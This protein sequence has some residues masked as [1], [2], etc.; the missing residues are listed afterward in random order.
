AAFSDAVSKNVVA[1]DMLRLMRGTRYWLFV[2]LGQ[3]LLLCTSTPVASGWIFRAAG[4]W[5]IVT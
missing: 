4:A 3:T 2:F 5:L 1:D